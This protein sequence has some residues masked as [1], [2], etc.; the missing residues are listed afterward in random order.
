[1]AVLALVNL[2]LTGT[3]FFYSGCSIEALRQFANE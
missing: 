1:V 2:H 3:S